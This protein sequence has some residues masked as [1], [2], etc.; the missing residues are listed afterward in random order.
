VSVYERREALN[1][2]R[3][4]DR[5]FVLP[6][7]VRPRQIWMACERLDR[8]A[9]SG[10]GGSDGISHHGL[11]DDLDWR[12][13]YSG[14]SGGRVFWV[15]NQLQGVP[16]LYSLSVGVHFVDID[17]R[18]SRIPRVIVEQVQEIHVCPHVIA[19]CDD[20]VGRQR[21]RRRVRA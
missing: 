3:C 2:G 9:L 7:S 19:D 20:A 18:D 4:G 21:E 15:T 10:L 17:T 6:Y 1:F 5:A 12:E 11:T 16:M 8:A 14:R 13:G